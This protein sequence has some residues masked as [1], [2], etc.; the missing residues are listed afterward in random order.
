M[1]VLK[2]EPLRLDVVY[3]PLAMA[4]VV[5]PAIFIAVVLW[6]YGYVWT[7]PAPVFLALAGHA[8]FFWARGDS[9]CTLKLDET[10]IALNDAR[11]GQ[12]IA[13]AVDRIRSA[14]MNL[15]TREDGGTTAVIV[16][17]DDHHPLLAIR[18]ACPKTAAHAEEVDGD[19]ITAS[20]GG[21]GGTA[22]A[23]APV[24]AV[25]RQLVRD[26]SGALI[27][28]YRALPDDVRARTHIRFWQGQEPVLDLL[29]RHEEEYSGIIR[30]G[31]TPELEVNGEASSLETSWSWSRASRD[32]LLIQTAEDLSG[33]STR[34]MH[35]AVLQLGQ[36]QIAFPAPLASDLG[37]VVEL[38]D[39]TLHT[40][41][42]EGAALLYQLLRST[43]RGRWPTPL[44]DALHD[45]RAYLTGPPGE[46]A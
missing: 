15:R 17:W 4:M 23:F 36:R 42:G 43:P 30:L 29:G 8:A 6:W 21:D 31:E 39:D 37:E 25:C 27:A 28:W 40:H 3:R 12:Q 7:A 18:A 24:G 46:V 45:A 9:P 19:V 22:Y 26:P 38:T 2:G 13:V 34:T 5:P 35:L 32:V 20:I 14:S 41:S 10:R 11:R 33:P 44:R 1:T 16:L